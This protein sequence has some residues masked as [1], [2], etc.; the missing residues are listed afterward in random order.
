MSPAS[1]ASFASGLSERWG[2]EG[3]KKAFYLAQLGLGLVFVLVLWRLRPQGVSK[4]SGF[5]VRE[6][7]LK[8]AAPPGRG[9]G[10]SSLADGP[11]HEVLG[12]SP[13]AS[14][15]EIQQAYRERMKQY[16]PDRVGRPGTREWVDAQKIAEAI[17]HAKNELL[18][19][20]RER[21]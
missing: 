5:A 7:D 8:A 20:A 13:R 1:L 2:P 14:V 18:K 17:N 3:V 16:H 19:R 21:T 9:A 4:D 12:I 15:E 11:P 6:A 10:S